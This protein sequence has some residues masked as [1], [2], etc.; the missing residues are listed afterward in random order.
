MI[1]V[2]SFSWL[3]F[4]CLSFLVYGRIF[5][6]YTIGIM[7]GFAIFL[8]GLYVFIE[9]LVGVTSWFNS[10]IGSVL[11]GVGCYIWIRGSIEVLNGYEE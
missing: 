4:V 3:F 11:F 6:D 9:G 10:V 1:S 5:K 8:L 7:G 2:S